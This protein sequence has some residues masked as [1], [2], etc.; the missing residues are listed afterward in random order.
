MQAMRLM[1]AAGAVAVT[2]S[3]AVIAQARSAPPAATGGGLAIAPA[4]IDTR[5]APGAGGVVTIA[6][7]S[8]KPLDVSVAARPW[9]QGKDGAVSPNRAKTLANVSVSAD[10]F[11]LAA[12]AS[13]QVT[14]ALKGMPAAG[15]LYAG[16][17]I[18]GLPQD[19]AKRKG[20]ITGYRLIGTLRLEPASPVHALKAGAALVSGSGSAR[21]LALPVRNAGNT[22]DAVSASVSLKGSLG[23]HQSDVAGV[24]ILPGKTV[25]LKLAK[26]STLP[27]GR[28]TAT[29]SLQQGTQK[30]KVVRQISVKR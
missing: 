21:E 17:D 13:R 22:I 4:T 14:V 16:L 7:R 27:A 5:A 25:D 15:S 6:N 23:T 26:A 10:R 1:F 8:D 3:G 2:V 9:T 24:R 29:V 30:L 12:G 20:I 19:I 18:V 28:Y 11:T